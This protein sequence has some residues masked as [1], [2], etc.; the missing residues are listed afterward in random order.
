MQIECGWREVPMLAWQ[1]LLATQFKCNSA[2]S[3]QEIWNSDKQA[4]QPGY[5]EI[6]TSR[7]PNRNANSK[8]GERMVTL[9]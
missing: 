8:E 9:I 7:S 6:P 5:Q 4:G 1:S 2:A 3:L